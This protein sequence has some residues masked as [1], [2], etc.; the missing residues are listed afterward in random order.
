MALSMLSKNQ[1]EI[2]DTSDEYVILRD[3]VIYDKGIR[4]MTF[5][6]NWTKKR[7]MEST[8]GATQVRFYQIILKCYLHWEKNTKGKNAVRR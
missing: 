3:V 1:V 8:S 6:R 2:Y 7:E 4:E 5:E